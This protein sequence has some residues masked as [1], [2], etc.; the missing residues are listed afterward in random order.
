MKNCGFLIALIAA[1]FYGCSSVPLSSDTTAVHS[2]S[3][4]GGAGRLEQHSAQ[5]QRALQELDERI[6]RYPQD[7]EALLL[8]GLI[9]FESRQFE[10]ALAALD[11]VVRQAPQFHLAQMIKGDILMSRVAKV[12][13]I[14][15][16]ALLHAIPD[17]RYV[18]VEDLREE[19]RMRLRAYL[20]RQNRQKLPGQLL[21]MGESVETAVLVDK[22]THRLYLFGNT[23]VDRPPELLYDFYISTG[24][25]RGNK[26]WKGDLRTPEGVYFVTSFMPGSR[27]PEKY[28]AAA[29]PINYPNELDRHQRKSGGGIWLHGITRAFYSRPP[30]DSEGCIVL[31]NIDLEQIAALISPGSTPFIIAGRL[32]WLEEDVW[33]ERKN[34][35]M[36]ALQIWREDWE[37]GDISRYQA[38]YSAN[39]WTEE[40]GLAGQAG[41]ERAGIR[42]ARISI[43]DLSLLAYPRASDVNQDIVVADFR[44]AFDADGS[45]GRWKKRLYLNREQGRWYVLHEADLTEN[46]VAVA[47]IDSLLR[48][49]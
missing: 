5:V 26:A 8:K 15:H 6:A 20:Q 10:R 17:S 19:A 3:F 41:G 18:L 2:V 24:R 12:S 4:S 35:V 21:R 16:N 39:F 25:K 40:S 28:G 42:R 49:D 14:G 27:L 11:S 9:H 37:S 38:H 34:S 44:L 13:G 7:Y 1:V 45:I 48:P 43:D 32:D 47:D 30:L 29:F 31:S 36:Q 33:L 23:G 46:G 22:Q